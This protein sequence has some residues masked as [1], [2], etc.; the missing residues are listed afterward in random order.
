[1]S[2]LG[3]DWN[4]LLFPWRKAMA[5]DLEFRRAEALG[6]VM[7]L[8]SAHEDEILPVLRNAFEDASERFADEAKSYGMTKEEYARGIRNTTPEDRARHWQR[9]HELEIGAALVTPTGLI[10]PEDAQMARYLAANGYEVDA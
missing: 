7:A 3:I 4:E 5:Q 10:T 9:M 2:F 8:K 6:R 1:M